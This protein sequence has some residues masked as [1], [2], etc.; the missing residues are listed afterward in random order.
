MCLSISTSDA[1]TRRRPSSLNRTG[2]GRT[3]K[4]YDDNGKG[5]GK[6]DGGGGGANAHLF[7]WRRVAV[8]L[9]LAVAPAAMGAAAVATHLGRGLPAQAE[10]SVTHSA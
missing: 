3:D 5:D 10:S 4:K 7:S 1:T 9:A 8:V 6:R 2:G